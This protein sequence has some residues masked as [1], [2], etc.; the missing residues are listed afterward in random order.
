MSPQRPIEQARNSDLR[1]SAAAL[2]R[3]ALRAREIAIRTQTALVVRRNGQ[4]VH[5]HMNGTTETSVTPTKA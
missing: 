4:L 1:G 2:T 5:D 3:A